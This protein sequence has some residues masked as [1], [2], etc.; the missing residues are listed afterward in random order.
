MLGTHLHHYS[1][2]TTKPAELEA[3]HALCAKLNDGRHW[4]HCLGLPSTMENRRKPHGT[5]ETVELETK[6]LF[7]NQWN[8]ADHG[9]TKGRRLFDW[10]EGIYPN[11]AL[12]AG[13]YLDITPDMR[14]VRE[15]TLVCGYCGAHYPDG[16]GA[17]IVHGAKFCNR[18]TDSAYLKETDLCLLRL[19]PVAEHFPKRAELS[20]E[21]T[22]VLVPVYARQQTHATATNF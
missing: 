15:S 3:Y 7:S 19:A 9:D 6:F 5:T 4:M 22:A 14:A 17:H 10:Y 13:H 2:D 20:V 16:D 12:K 18:C 1:F 11:T 8:E 21:E